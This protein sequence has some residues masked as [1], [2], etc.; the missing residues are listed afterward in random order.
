MALNVFPIE[1]V[2]KLLSDVHDELKKKKVKKKNKSTTVSISL[3]AGI[4]APRQR[5]TGEQ[6]A[7]QELDKDPS[8]NFLNMS[9][10]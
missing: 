6:R 9:D 2:V 1:L 5:K 7:R 10:V 3:K 8:T 4:T